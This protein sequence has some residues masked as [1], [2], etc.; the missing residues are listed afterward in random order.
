MQYVT[1]PPPSPANQRTARILLGL[2]LLAAGLYT[3]SGFLHALAWAGILAVATWP[4][5]DRAERRFGTSHTLLPLVFTLGAV[6]IVII[7]LALV[8]TQ[9][10]HEARLGMQ[11]IGG[12]RASGVP[13]PDWLP[14]LPL[15]ATQ[16]TA[17]WDANLTHPEDARRLL[18]SFDRAS[19][20]GLSRGLGGA[21]VHQAV[22]VAFT[23]VTLFFLFKSG[24]ELAAK[25]LWATEQLFGPG[26]VRLTTQIVASIHG[27]VDGMV[28]VGLG[29]GAL[30]GLGYWLAGVPHPVV[31]GT[32]T[33][34]AALIPMGAPVVLAI[35]AAIVLVQGHTLAAALLAGL[36]MA[37]VFIADH[38]VRPALIGGATKLPFL[39][40]LLGILGGV[41]TFGLLGLFLGPAIMAALILLWRE[42]T[43]DATPDASPLIRTD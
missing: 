28:L 34:G 8:A 14:T 22:I 3:L 42:W 35:T 38:A 1:N 7:P 33:A 6:L 26:G 13:V 20:L 36:G 19:L 37:V 4:L 17:W 41:E 31:F 27:T 2:A 30:L 15:F 12:A 43:G 10:G 16:A 23:L 18:S 9:V 11:F 5:F 32:L 40:V 21:V 25:A 29:V 39:W 24:R